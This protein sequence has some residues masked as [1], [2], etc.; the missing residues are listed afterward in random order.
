MRSVHVTCNLKTA[1][2]SIYRS[3]VLGA[4]RGEQAGVMYQMQGITSQTRKAM[5]S[6]PTFPRRALAVG[7]RVAS[8]RR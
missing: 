7:V 2:G 1:A 6:A 8:W 3:P 4:D 5:V